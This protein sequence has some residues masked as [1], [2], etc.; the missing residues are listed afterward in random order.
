GDETF[1]VT[2][3]NARGGASLG[4]PSVATVTIVDDESA[5]Q[6]SADGYVTREGAPAVITLQRSGALSTAATVNF[7]ATAGTAVAG[8]DFTP[9]STVVSFPANV[10]SKTVTVPLLN[11][12]LVQGN[13]TVLLA[14]SGPTGGAQIGT[15]GTAVLTITE[16]DQG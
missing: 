4:L 5:I 9:V 7:S 14:L 13:R 1:M 3:S 12:T 6:L 11:N 15:R 8:R 10:A 16:D 2:L